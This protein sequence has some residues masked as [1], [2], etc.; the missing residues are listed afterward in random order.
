MGRTTPETGGGTPQNQSLSEFK[1][2]SQERRVG[3]GVKKPEEPK[4]Q[5]ADSR[6]ESYDRFFKKGPMRP[7]VLEG[8][9][10]RRR[11]DKG[12]QPK[13]LNYSHEPVAIHTAQLQK[14]G[15]LRPNTTEPKEIFRV[16]YGKPPEGE[17]PGD[18]SKYLSDPHFSGFARRGPMRPAVFGGHV[19]PNHQRKDEDSQAKP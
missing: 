2:L 7:A 10:P 8:I 1:P 15:R 5:P 13:P 3:W 11:N 18:A 9:P 4:Q 17:V 19:R 6:W 12:A 14:E 16:F